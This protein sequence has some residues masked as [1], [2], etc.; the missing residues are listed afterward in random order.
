VRRVALAGMT[1]LQSLRLLLC[2]GARQ[3]SLLVGSDLK[4]RFWSALAIVVCAAACLSLL[5]Q[6]RPILVWN[7]SASSVRGLY[8]VATPGRLRRGDIVIAWA[9]PAARRL[10]AERGY[11]PLRV[12]LV[13]PVAAIAGDRVCAAGKRILVN[14]RV[15][16]V[17][18]AHDRKG[19][20]LP[21]RSGCHVLRR[22]ELFLLSTG[23]AEAFDGRYFGI[24][25]SRDV[26]G[27]ASL[28]WASPTK[29]SHGG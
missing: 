8:R 18:R 13:K 22:G 26:V 6:P 17:R 25:H 28:L 7:S 2:G 1:K 24:T 20:L 14:G 12:P 9:P 21:R 5:W 27:K 3:R 10:A 15:A 11:L 16:A 23:V 19:R 4:I 29:A